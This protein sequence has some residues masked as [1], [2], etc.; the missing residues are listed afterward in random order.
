V[1]Q[2]RNTPKKVN[3]PLIIVP[4][5]DLYDKDIRK[6]YMKLPEHMHEE[7][8]KEYL[9]TNNRIQYDLRF[10]D[11]S[12]LPNTITELYNANVYGQLTTSLIDNIIIPVT[13]TLDLKAIALDKEVCSSIF[14]VSY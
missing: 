1:D 3:V 7:H 12:S 4:T 11:Q 2:E 13:H 9:T 8:K 6:L 10:K 14:D 5:A